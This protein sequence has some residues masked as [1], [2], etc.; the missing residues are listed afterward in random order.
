MNQIVVGCYQFEVSQGTPEV[1]LSRVG[2]SLPAFAK[3]GCRLLV[4]PEMWSCGFVYPQ[5]R[6]MAQR[7]PAIVDKM[8]EWARRY[9]MVLVGSLPEIDGESVFNT[10]YVIDATGEVA[11]TYRKVHLFSLHGEDRHFNRGNRSLVCST[12]VGRLGILICYDLRFPELARR[13]ALDGAELI[14]ISAIW[15][16]TRVEHWSLLLRARA[17]ENQLFVVGCNG[18]G[19]D[20]NFLYGGASAIVHPTGQVLAKADDRETRMTAKTD[21]EEMAAFRRHLTCFADRLPGI[22]NIV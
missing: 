6:D 21:M 2:E 4:L 22:Y 1:N 14:C 7:T 17:L 16:M 11:G 8:K 12:T 3:E 10:S 15:P 5:L 18:C 9:Q 20:Q 19:K 13:L